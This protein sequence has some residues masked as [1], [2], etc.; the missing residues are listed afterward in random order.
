[1]AVKRR[2]VVDFDLPRQVIKREVKGGFAGG[3]NPDGVVQPNWVTRDYTTDVKPI[4]GIQ[5][6]VSE[7]HTEWRKSNLPSGDVG[8]D[9][10][11][12]KRYISPSRMGTHFFV[13]PWYSDGGISDPRALY[14]YTY[15]GPLYLSSMI[16]NGYPP[17]GTSSNGGLNAKGTTA[18]ARC[19]PGNPVAHLTT[20]VLEAFKDGLPHLVGHTFWA[21]RTLHAQRAFKAGGDEW[22]NYQF[23][24]LP[25]IGDIK[26]FVH[27]VFSLNRLI[28]QYVR[29]SGKVVRRRYSF[30]PEVS[31]TNLST[32]TGVRPNGPGDSTAQLV[33]STGLTGV[34]T[35]D[36]EIVVNTW[37]SG[38]FTYHMPPNL[39]AGLGLAGTTF[40]AAQRLLGADLSPDVLW[41][42]APWSWAVDWFSNAG[43]VIHNL[44]AMITDG[45]VMRYGYVM[46]HAIVRDK[47]LFSGDLGLRSGIT[48]SGAVEPVVLTSES[49][50]RRRATPFGFGLDMSALTGRQQSIIAALGLSRLR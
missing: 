42:L 37:F 35:R 27:G 7:N 41:E 13:S 43:D 9:F 47:Y 6:T 45:L 16:A 49:K 50:V 14:R 15:K 23:S 25:L 21:E 17:F 31:L 29:D 26:D 39:F 48:Y 8:G 44:S 10:T 12:T 30:P 20:A 22:L 2:R 33:R 32:Q 34:A 36:R 38:S 46:E 4:Q 19:A 28:A 11:T 3:S 40:G 18:I 1:M 5:E 24:W